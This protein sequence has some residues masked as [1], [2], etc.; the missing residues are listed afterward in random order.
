MHILPWKY[1]PCWH[2]QSSVVP[3][4]VLPLYV[5]IQLVELQMTTRSKQHHRWYDTSYNHTLKPA[6]AEYFFLWRV[7]LQY[8]FSLLLCPLFCSKDVL[9]FQGCL[10]A[11]I[12]KSSTYV[13]SRNVV[14]ISLFSTAY[15]PRWYLSVP[16]RRNCDWLRPSIALVNLSTWTC[17]IFRSEVLHD[18]YLQ[19]CL[20]HIACNS[21]R[22]H[23]FSNHNV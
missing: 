9:L 11:L 6:K 5:L 10:S 3:L 17:R 12:S 2:F 13:S 20:L 4:P 16:S 19:K 15:F 18:L 14:A 8:K 1:Y 7:W 23:T 22:V 21:F